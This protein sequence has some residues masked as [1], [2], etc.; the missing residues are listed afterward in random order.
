MLKYII[1]KSR[2]KGEVSFNLIRTKLIEYI[3]EEKQLA[4]NEES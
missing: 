3:D 4:S 2:S 1:F